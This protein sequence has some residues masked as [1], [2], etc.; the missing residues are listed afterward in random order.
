MG[1]A[2]QSGVVDATEFAVNVG[3][4]HAEVRER[5]DDTWIF[6]SPV[7]PG[8]GQELH[9]AIV[10][11]RRHTI[12]VQL[13]LVQPLRARGRLLDRLGELGRHERREGGVASR[14]AGFYALRGRA[15]DD[16]RIGTNSD[17]P[18]WVHQ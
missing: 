2:W 1:K 8:P 6:G 7:E 14:R 17:A 16:T 12:A 3:G 13:D 18:A 9:T 11:P 4:L 10:D 5:G 15:L